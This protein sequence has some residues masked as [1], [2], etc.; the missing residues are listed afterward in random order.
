MPKIPEIYNAVHKAIEFREIV[1]EPRPYLGMSGIGGDCLRAQWFGFRWASGNRILE[2]RVKRIFQ[3]GDL[4]EE[5]IITDLREVGVDVYMLMPDGSKFYPKGIREEYQEEIVHFTGH[6]KGHI[7]G[8]AINVPGAEK[9]EHL[10]EFKTMK[11]SKFADYK[12][13]GLKNFQSYSGQRQLYMGYLKLM[14]C[15]YI[16]TNKDTE[17]RSYDR[18]HFDLDIFN[19]AKKR[20]LTVLGTDT[21]PL[22]I[23][24]S[25]DYFKCKFCSHKEVCYKQKPVDKNC[26]TCV[27]A[28]LHDAGLWK[29]KGY[30]IP[31][32]VQRIGCKHYEALL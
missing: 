17:E 7:D 23:G 13:N 24:R 12:K 27:N 20:I 8:R 2:P 19:W 16:V 6:S 28:E 29:C 32:A 9:T 3:R 5:R 15:L 18:A 14:R 30:D 22:G 21:P 25:P 10:C 31:I 26:R 4:E 1:D 11:A